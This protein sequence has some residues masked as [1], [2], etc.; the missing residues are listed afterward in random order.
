M[1]SLFRLKTNLSIIVARIIKKFVSAKIRALAKLARKT[2][3]VRWDEHELIIKK[4]I[5]LKEN[6]SK[7]FILL[8]IYNALEHSWHRNILEAYFIKEQNVIN[9]SLSVA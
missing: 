5:Y 1:P 7:I 9:Y 4:K 2:G 6:K 8:I 3:H